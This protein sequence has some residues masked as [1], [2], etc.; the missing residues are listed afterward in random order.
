MCFFALK[1]IQA[2]HRPYFFLV[3]NC[4]PSYWYLTITYV[5]SIALPSF[6]GKTD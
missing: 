2:K 1:F 6:L 5:L 3:V 4:L